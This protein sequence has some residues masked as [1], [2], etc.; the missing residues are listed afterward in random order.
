[1]DEREKSAI[2]SVYR[3]LIKDIILDQDFK[4]ALIEKKVFS[5]NMISTIMAEE[6]P[7]NRNFKM[8]ELIEKRGPEAFNKFVEILKEQHLWLATQLLQKYE[9]K[10]QHCHITG[11]PYPTNVK[12]M[13]T[14]EPHHNSPQSVEQH[15][16]P[17]IDHTY[18]E[19]T[20]E[21]HHKSSQWVGQHRRPSIDHTY[22]EDTQEPHHKSSQWVGQHGRPLFDHTY[23]EDTQEPHHKSSQWVGQHG[24]PLFDHTYQE[25]TQEPHHKSSHWVRQHRRPSIDHTYQ[26]EI[27]NERNQGK[28][29]HCST[30]TCTGHKISKDSCNS[31]IQTLNA[32]KYA[33]KSFHSNDCGT[34]SLGSTMS[35][36]ASVEIRSLFQSQIRQGRD[37]PDA[38]RHSTSRQSSLTESLHEHFE[39]LSVED[40][41]Q[42]ARAQSR[43]E[44]KSALGR[45]QEE[46]VGHV[47]ELGMG[48]ANTTNIEDKLKDLYNNLL[49]YNREHT[50][51]A[52]NDN[53]DNLD[54]VEMVRIEI[55][56]VKGR[57]EES[58]DHKMMKRCQMLFQDNKNPLHMNIHNLIT[59]YHNTQNEIKKL[60]RREEKTAKDMY[61]NQ[62]TE[63]KIR[64]LSEQ[65][66]ELEEKVKELQNKVTELETTVQSLKAQPE[67]TKSET[68]DP[69][70][71]QN[72]VTNQSPRKQQQ[73][74][75]FMTSRCAAN[76]EQSK[77]KPNDQQ[78]K[79]VKIHEEDSESKQKVEIPKTNF[80]HEASDGSNKHD[81]RS[82]STNK[83][84]AAFK[85]TNTTP[86]RLT[87]PQRTDKVA[88]YTK[89]QATVMKAP[90]QTG[91][92]SFNFQVQEQDP[93]SRQRT[94]GLKALHSPHK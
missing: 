75:T 19:D 8:L 62:P 49:S 28:S 33:Y 51:E 81:K 48:R 3:D 27:Q 2:R 24:R 79:H 93:K 40:F 10:K 70:I 47:S 56:K 9:E 20:Q 39:L 55:D 23:Q 13:V 84:D 29:H 53:A 14:A 68:R 69:Y 89:Q 11:S 94:G 86:R 54:T 16:R 31:P 26:E 50:G 78:Q 64:H 60:K 30:C 43:V 32:N 67:H 90:M 73:K 36:E 4:G 71:Q 57:I 22:Q 59:D 92:A 46:V 61:E 74:A 21:P 88:N 35:S 37:N 52:E 1:M 6:T 91:M 66:F 85:H 15:R 87:V 44:S 7:M 34:Q 38:F 77:P 41:Y 76:N 65:K 58:D 82:H 17:S 12:Y 18:Q 72:E 83:P 42:H 45:I 25:D 80:P 5:T 63:F